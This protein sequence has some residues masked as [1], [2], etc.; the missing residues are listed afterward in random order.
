VLTIDAENTRGRTELPTA[1]TIT[2]GEAPDAAVDDMVTRKE[3][4]ENQHE[5]EGSEGSVT[6][7]PFRLSPSD[8]SR[9]HRQLGH[10]APSQL[11]RLIRNS[12]TLKQANQAAVEQA[13]RNHYCEFCARRAHRR[14]PTRPAVSVSL[15]SAPGQDIHLDVGYF[16]HPHLGPFQALIATDKFSLFVSGGVFQ[17]PVTAEKTVELFITS[18]DDT[19]ERVTYDL[20]ANFRSEI[21]RSTLERLGS[22]A[23]AVPK[24]ARWPSA[25]EKNVELLRIELD[26]VF[27]EFPSVST[28]FAYAAAVHR[29]N[30]RATWAHDISRRVVHLGRQPC[31]PRLQEHLFAQAP[32]WLPPSMSD[33]ENFISLCDGKR[34]SHVVHTAR[35]RLKAALHRRMAQ[36]NHIVLENGDLFLYWRTG[37]SAVQSGYKGPAVCLGVYRAMVVGF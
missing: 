5:D 32:S 35:V 12:A 23:W 27:A 21:F 33:V 7:S 16:R 31:A 10:P 3:Q 8:V 11:L 9:M 36:A 34:R 17:G 28:R 6:T 26:A 37:I 13:V 4:V 20:G 1:T 29:L 19:Y 2:A 22:Q 18:V 30:S 25:S 15:V 24:N 14:T